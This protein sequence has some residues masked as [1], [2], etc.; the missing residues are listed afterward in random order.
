MFQKYKVIIKGGGDLASAVAYKLHRVG[1]PVIIT[2]LAKP[3]MV[4][5]SVSFGNCVYENEWTVEG[6]TAVLIQDASQI[7]SILKERKIPVLIDPFCKVK[8]SICPLVLIDGILAKKNCGTQIA[9]APIVIGLGPGFTAVEDVHMVIETN[10]GHDLG[11]VLYKG[12]AEKNT[13][14]PGSIKGYT[15]ERVLRAGCRGVVKNKKEIGD[16]VEQGDIICYVGDATIRA[17]ISGILR[18]LIHE[19]VLVKKYEKIG[20][21]DP[22]GEKDYCYTIS[23]KGRNVAGGVLEGILSLL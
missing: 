6:V 14:V 17:N 8:D 13:G 18:G 20:D 11:R 1:F 19:D 5:R 7:D 23:D 12:K 22:R 3:K 15:T 4:R 21:I 2:E 10:R 9:D 16:V